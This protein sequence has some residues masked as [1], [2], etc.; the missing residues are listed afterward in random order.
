V[1]CKADKSKNFREI[2]KDV[3]QDIKKKIDSAI[4]S[5]EDKG[6]NLGYPRSSAIKGS[7]L[8]LRELRITAANQEWRILY[9]FHPMRNP[10]L[11]HAGDK[12][13]E[14]DSW[15]KK[16]IPVAEK[17]YLDFLQ[18]D[19]KRLYPEADIKNEI[20][21]TKKKVQNQTHARTI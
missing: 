15:Y 16:N 19:F 8:S 6:T 18:N 14:G 3:S 7:K 9:K 11:L 12:T 21:M 4:F 2:I 17:A 13:R 5:L 10:V 1:S 20:F